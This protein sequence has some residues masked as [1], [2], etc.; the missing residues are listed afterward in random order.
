MLQKGVEE[1]RIL[2]VLALAAMALLVVACGGKAHARADTG[3]HPEADAAPHPRSDS[4][5]SPDAWICL[6]FLRGG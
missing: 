4:H 1:L 6:R 3:P 2:T 5:A